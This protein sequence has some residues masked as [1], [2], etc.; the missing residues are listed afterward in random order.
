VIEA[1]GDVGEDYAW[2][3]PTLDHGLHVWVTPQACWGSP[4]TEIRE[5]GRYGL[6]GPPASALKKVK[7][8]IQLMDAYLPTY[9]LWT[10]SLPDEDYEDLRVSGRWPVFQR[11]L[12]ESVTRLIR[13]AGVPALAIGVVELGARRSH[14][15]GRPMPHIHMAL[16]GWGARDATGQWLLRPAVMDE[17][18][19]RACR[20]AGLP[21]RYRAPGSKIEERLKTLAGYLSKYMSKGGDIGLVDTSDGWEALIPHQWWNRSK[22]LKELA[23][24]HTWRLPRAFAA[25]VEQH[26]RR[27]EALALGVGRLVSLGRRVTKTSDRSIDVLCFS[28][29]G[30]EE[31]HQAL[32]WFAIWRADPRA[33]ERE[34]DRCTSLRTLA[35]DGA[36]VGSASAAEISIPGFSRLEMEWLRRVWQRRAS[37]AALEGALTHA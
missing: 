2:N 18:I 34:A 3:A 22:E 32:E 17:L 30:V 28:F 35:C 25:F 14:R 4:S 31:L 11:E 26:R 33:F 6:D 36:D 21:D 24:G 16:A 23:D 29:L 9:A 1:L 5:K 10:A 37:Q 27:L 19:A 13:G 20:K 7:R 8:S 15:T 12:F